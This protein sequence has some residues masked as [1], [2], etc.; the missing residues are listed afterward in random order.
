MQKSH[1][2]SFQKIIRLFLQTLV[3]LTLIVAIGWLI[4]EPGFEPVLA[5]LAS[6]AVFLTPL[7]LN[8]EEKEKH[9]GMS[10]TDECELAPEI[11]LDVLGVGSTV[12]GDS[13]DVA[14][15]LNDY[16]SNDERGV[17]FSG[18]HDEMAELDA[19]LTQAKKRFG[20]LVAP[21]GMGKSALVANWTKHLQDSEQA[22]VAYHPISLRYGTNS[23]KQ[24]L[25]SLL[26]QMSDVIRKEAALEPRWSYVEG[27]D[28][29]D[30]SFSK[31]ELQELCF[32]LSVDYDNLGEGGK[33]NKAQELIRLCQRKGSL[34]E[35]VVL[36]REMRPHHDWNAAFSRSTQD[37]LLY[38]PPQEG[39][40]EQLLSKQLRENL[41]LS[42]GWNKPLVVIIDGL[43]E[44]ANQLNH[45]DIQ[46]VNF[47]PNETGAGIYILAVA[48]GESV[49]I[50]DEWLR[51]LKWNKLLTE[52]FELGTLGKEDVRE[53]VSRSKLATEDDKLIL[54]ADKIYELSEDGDPLVASLWIDRLANL[55]DRRIESLLEILENGDP[56]INGYVEGIFALLKPIRSGVAKPLFEVLS[57]ARGPLTAEDL[58]ALGIKIDSLQ[59]KQ[60]VSLSGRLIIRNAQYAYGFSHSRIRQAVQDKY[61]SEDKRVYWLEKFHLYGKCSLKRAKDLFE[62]QVPVISPYILN[63][64][65]Q[66]L[67]EDMPPDYES[68]L[69]A[70][71]DEVWMKAHYE[72]FGSYD[73]FLDD[74]QRVW[75]VAEE[76]GNQIGSRSTLAIQFKCALV[77]SKAVSLSGHYLLPAL[78]LR[79]EL[80]RLPSQALAQIDLLP[81]IPDRIDAWLALLEIEE[82]RKKLTPRLIS[83]IVDR[84][85][86][87]LL[88]K[89]E[90][91]AK[92]FRK[93][94]RLMA[95]DETFD[96][97]QIENMKEV[98]D[99]FT[100]PLWR[101][102]GLSVILPLF[103]DPKDGT[104][105]IVKIIISCLKIEERDAYSHLPYLY[106]T[107]ATNLPIDLFSTACQQAFADV[108]TL[109]RRDFFE[110]VA[111]EIPPEKIESF[112]TIL[113]EYL[114]Y[115][116]YIAE[117]IA[118][119]APKIDDEQAMRIANE[120]A[121][122]FKEVPEEYP[123]SPYR[124]A[125]WVYGAVGCGPIFI[126]LAAQRKD[127]VYK[128]RLLD[129]AQSFIIEFGADELPLNQ[130][131][132]WTL[133]RIVKGELSDEKVAALVLED[134]F[135]RQY[136][137]ENRLN[138]YSHAVLYCLGAETITALFKPAIRPEEK[139]SDD[140][141][142]QWIDKSGYVLPLIASRFSDDEWPFISR[143]GSADFG[144]GYLRAADKNFC[145]LR[146]PR[147][148]INDLFENWLGTDRVFGESDD[149]L[150]AICLT[151][152]P[153]VRADDL[154]ATIK[155][156]SYLS[157]RNILMIFRMVTNP[158]LDP[159]VFRQ[160]ALLPFDFGEQE[161]TADLYYIWVLRD[162]EK[163]KVLLKKLQR[164]Y[165]SDAD[166]IN[167]ISFLS[168]LTATTKSLRNHWRLYQY[169]RQIERRLQG[170]GYKLWAATEKSLSIIWSAIF[171][172][173][174]RFLGLVAR[175]GFFK[176]LLE[177]MYNV[178]WFISWPV[179]SPIL[180]YQEIRVR[181]LD[182][183]KEQE[184][185]KQL[186]S[187]IQ[188]INQI[189]STDERRMALAKFTDHVI[190]LN[191]AF[192]D[193]VFQK[194]VVT[195]EKQNLWERFVYP[196]DAL[197]VLENPRQYDLD[198]KAYPILIPAMLT[199]IDRTKYSLETLL[200]A[201]SKGTY[202]VALHNF[203]LNQIVLAYFLKGDEQIQVIEA[204]IQNS[205]DFSWVEDED[206]GNAIHA[207]AYFVPQDLVSVILDWLQVFSSA[208]TLAVL[209]PKIIAHKD[210]EGL[211]KQAI[212]ILERLSD[213]SPVHRFICN[214]ASEL[215]GKDIAALIELVLKR[216]VPLRSQEI[217]WV[218]GSQNPDQPLE[219]YACLLKRWIS[220][221]ENEE[222]KSEAFVA[223]NLMLHSFSRRPCKDFFD[224]MQWF[225][226]IIPKLG[227]EQD[228]VAIG[229]TMLEVGQW[230]W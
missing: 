8:L 122:R 40:D 101:A 155:K 74:V 99:G 149:V 66:H 56:G 127:P 222:T 84:I 210:S 152:A 45:S 205:Q 35:L 223:W 118:N 161:P 229:E 19:W 164:R 177:T 41:R 220:L 182:L 112:V 103:S 29:I 17:Y 208:S 153:Y 168:R 141:R 173:L 190:H 85:T 26:I 119:M 219:S 16:L 163:R 20:F 145:R 36:C 169:H 96:A 73:G 9:E 146:L 4:F 214:I 133:Y 206:V 87:G 183:M 72:Y 136:F 117:L 30:E 83:Q 159:E 51:K 179:I 120:F 215:K 79:D 212:S 121:D 42:T 180:G 228:S 24:T 82:T 37:R 104:K 189:Q 230:Q 186:Q 184:R 78:L 227:S 100:N 90:T 142:Y 47:L 106:E 113:Y 28:L 132:L 162:T 62:N 76:V 57:L 88:L 200:D 226:E 158:E 55:E 2:I 48:R 11:Q 105:T 130:E 224:H 201:V 135:L 34:D 178:F 199:R 160:I 218:H 50:R 187:E 3:V 137:K 114:R 148:F 15:F 181:K 52:F 7:F 191:I 125:E 124:K 144:L 115:F 6:V 109:D 67:Q 71:I 176:A 31:E 12:I 97:I 111:W 156:S 46:E 10:F 213:K 91:Q 195:A 138:V 32:H 61:V 44:L 140:G 39:A 197:I 80:L 116:P 143:I 81:N 65:A 157:K 68:S 108:D 27:L 172:P 126:V 221:A 150:N 63:Y 192:P 38:E 13:G 185:W 198:F 93:L 92:R 211:L 110:Q 171:R 203:V 194:Y 86:L 147:K 167:Q 128:E 18:R 33:R 175:T 5:I 14:N 22:V 89:E 1:P 107:F 60:L 174:G 54:L 64:Y 193:N 204:A 225:V 59:L 165:S 77:S 98:A 53:M 207:L 131:D 43:D 154:L 134:K 21:A 25:R 202:E 188:R 123:W 209:A 166:C 170:R 196:E 216:D 139:P 217:N 129:L 70:L 95:L 49:E 151:I 94:C 69:Y 75:K 102:W 23:Q 58:Y